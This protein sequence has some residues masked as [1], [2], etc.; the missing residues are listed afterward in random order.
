MFKA[1]NNINISFKYITD[2]KTDMNNIVTP[3][4]ELSN[5]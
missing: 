5:I 3:K 2:N 4:N 1:W